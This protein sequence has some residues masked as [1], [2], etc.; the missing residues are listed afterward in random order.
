M[1]QTIEVE[2]IR[3]LDI[4]PGETL[5]VGLPERATREEME[6]VRAT[7]PNYLPDGVKVLITSA[8]IEL[9]VVGDGCPSSPA[10]TA[11]G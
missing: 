2:S 7:L 3:R 10:S 1:T 8:N 4:K 9:S 5:V 6:Q 11:A